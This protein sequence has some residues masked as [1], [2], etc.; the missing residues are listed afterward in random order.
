MRVTSFYPVLMSVR[1]AELSAFYQEHFG[2]ACT[3]ETER[4]V[5]RSGLPEV[6]PLRDEAF[7]QRHFIT[8]DP[9]GNLL[10]VI[11]NIEPNEQF[12]AN[13]SG[14]AQAQ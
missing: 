11:E 3:F 1:V 14:T 10:D 13:F 6:M 4:L 7:G 9:S 2:F 8:H 5:R 12:A